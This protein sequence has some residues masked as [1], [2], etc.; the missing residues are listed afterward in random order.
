MSTRKT[1]IDELKGTA[2]Q[3]KDQVEK[4]IK[5]GNARRVIVKNKEGK[6]LFESQLTIG[7]GGAA[8]LGFSAPI[9]TALSAVLL[10]AT[11]V[12][13]FIEKDAAGETTEGSASEGEASAAAGETH[14]IAIEDGEPNEALKNP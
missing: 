11:D 13:V 2:A 9:L 12:R 10:Y 14:V 3:I 1:I 5:E 8:I 7:L 4:L 6:V